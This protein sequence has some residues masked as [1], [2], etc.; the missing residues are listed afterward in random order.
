M[1]MSLIGEDSLEE[2]ADVVLTIPVENLLVLV[3]HQIHLPFV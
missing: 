1:A 2:K 3:P